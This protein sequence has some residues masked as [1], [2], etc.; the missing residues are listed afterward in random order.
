[1]TQINQFGW[2]SMFYHIMVWGQSCHMS[3]MIVKK[4]QLRMHP[5]VSA[6]E[7]NYSMIAK[8]HKRLWI[9]GVIQ[10]HLGPVT[11]QV[12]VENLFWKRHADQLRYL[13]GSKNADTELMAEIPLDDA[14]P[15]VMPQCHP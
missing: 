14:S 9:K 10:D 13:A 2:L 3:Q 8:D 5:T 4:N 1:M 11:Y 12:M 7:Q 15:E 6:S